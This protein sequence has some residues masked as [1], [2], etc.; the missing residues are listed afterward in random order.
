MGIGK[1]LGAAIGGALLVSIL[2]KK[3]YCPV[4]KRKYRRKKKR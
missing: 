3:K 2:K 4:Y 1:L